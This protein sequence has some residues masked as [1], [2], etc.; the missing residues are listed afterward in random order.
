M[1]VLN[2]QC[3]SGTLKHK[4]WKNNMV[5]N[6]STYF[7]WQWNIWPNYHTRKSLLSNIATKSH[8][9]CLFLQRLTPS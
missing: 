8:L 9:R 5:L 1:D 4:I 6:S 7:C 3:V 2:F